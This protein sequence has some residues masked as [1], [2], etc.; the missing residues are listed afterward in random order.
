MSLQTALL[1]P[2][3]FPVQCMKRDCDKLVTDLCDKLVTD[4]CDKL[5]ADLCDK[6]VTDLCDKLV[7]DLCAISCQPSR[8]APYSQQKSWSRHSVFQGTGRGA[9]RRKGIDSILTGTFAS[10]LPRHGAG[11]QEMLRGTRGT[12]T[13][14]LPEPGGPS[15]PHH[16]GTHGL[17][18]VQSL[19]HV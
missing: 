13:L 2:R 5:V 7:A 12:V 18:V 19:S 11:I 10:L 9:C 17:L 4:L 8:P 16:P 3:A 15:P 14:P 1:S 6:L